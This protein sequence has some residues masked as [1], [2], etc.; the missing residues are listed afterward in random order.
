MQHPVDVVTL[1]ETLISFGANEPGRIDGVATFRKRL[2]GAETNTAIGLAR[3]GAAVTWISRL[4]DDPFG[5]EIIRTL[6]GE[7]VDVSAVARDTGAP[8]GLMVKEFRT[9]GETRVHYYRAASAASA[10]SAADVDEA[11][12]ARA[13]RVHLTGITLALGPG[14]RAAAERLLACAADHD[15]PVSFDPNLRL[16]LTGP[17]AAVESWHAVFPYVSDL[18]LSEDEARLCTTADT[19]DGMLDELAGLG[20]SAVVIKR[21]AEGAVGV[22]GARRCSVAASGGAAIDSVGAGDA[23]NAGFL[24]GRLHDATFEECVETGVWVAGHVVGS[25]GDWEGLPTL[26]DYEAART[27]LRHA[28]VPR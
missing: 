11:L 21:G 10:L 15:V 3:L 14:P 8:T 25:Y 5:D 17:R 6:R 20:F 22:A 4:G 1:G 28:Q 16:K 18:L 9:R 23:F 7:R 2:G 13:R 27:D 12:V 24:F 19:A 26:G